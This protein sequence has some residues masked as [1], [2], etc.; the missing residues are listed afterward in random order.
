MGIVNTIT[1]SFGCQNRSET[2]FIQQSS[3]Y[4]KLFSLVLSQYITEKKNVL[5]FLLREAL[6]DQTPHRH[7]LMREFPAL[8]A[9]INITHTEAMI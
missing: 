4:Q 7:D 6:G 5:V 2:A 9:F 8:T 1:W 3:R